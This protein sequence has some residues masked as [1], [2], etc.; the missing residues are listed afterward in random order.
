MLA[1]VEVWINISL[2]E[3]QQINVPPMQIK[4]TEGGVSGIPCVRRYWAVLVLLP[5][6][7]RQARRKERT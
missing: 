2:Q 1:A 7:G 6:K 4:Q 5:R 3:A